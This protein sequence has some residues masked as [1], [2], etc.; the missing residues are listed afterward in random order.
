MGLRQTADEYYW[1]WEQRDKEEDKKK[2][3][4]EVKLKEID[5]KKQEENQKII[6][7]QNKVKMFWTIWNRNK[8]YKDHSGNYS[9]NKVKYSILNKK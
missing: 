7:N 5:Q 3:E 2:Q 4:E 1:L 9:I 6:L 8:L